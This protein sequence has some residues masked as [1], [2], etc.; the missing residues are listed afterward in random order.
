MIIGIIIVC[1]TQPK[2]SGMI[3]LFYIQSNLNSKVRF[4]TIKVN[5]SINTFHCDSMINSY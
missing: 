2:Q 1:F 5:F 4:V 3:I